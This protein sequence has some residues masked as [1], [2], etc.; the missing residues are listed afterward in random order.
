MLL[1]KFG[2][3]PGM[4]SSDRYHMAEGM[5]RAV[6]Y[7]EILHVI[8]FSAFAATSEQHGRE[9]RDEKRNLG[10]MHSAIVFRASASAL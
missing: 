7:L 3:S 2:K 4:H 6:T 8:R 5:H 9:L 1:V 10:K